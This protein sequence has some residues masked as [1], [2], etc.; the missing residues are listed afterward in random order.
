MSQH[1]IIFILQLGSAGYLAVRAYNTRLWYQSKFDTIPTR[2][3][4][5]PGIF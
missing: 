4:L 5:L 2:A 1:Y 3:C